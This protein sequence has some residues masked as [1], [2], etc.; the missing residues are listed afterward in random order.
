MAFG[1]LSAYGWLGE[2]PP[3]KSCHNQRTAIDLDGNS[4]SHQDTA[5]RH[6][7]LLGSLVLRTT[8]NTS[9]QT[10]VNWNKPIIFD[11]KVFGKTFQWSRKAVLHLRHWNSEGSQLEGCSS[12]EGEQS[13]KKLSLA[14]TSYL[15][16][17]A[18]ENPQKWQNWRGR[19]SLLAG[20]FLTVPGS[21]EWLFGSHCVQPRAA[22]HSQGSP[23]RVAQ[24][25]KHIETQ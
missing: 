20:L 9:S 16:F 15:H 25:L 14:T 10:A 24:G 23:M 3:W 12:K 21:W 18:C 19:L 6:Y 17:R 8:M 4:T 11:E 13:R 7:T 22:N 2:D 5:A 1:L